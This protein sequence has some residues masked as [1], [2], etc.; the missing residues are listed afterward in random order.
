MR[1]SER[2][3]THTIG[4]I[5]L[6]GKHEE[7]AILHLAVVDDA[8]QLLAGLLDARAV[9]RVND[10][11]E[12]LGAAKVVPP[13]GANLVLASDVPHVEPH[14]L[15]RHRLDVEAHGGNRRHVLAQLELVQDRRL[16]G[17]VEAQHEEAHLLGSE[18]LAH[19]FGQR[20]TH[21]DGQHA[22]RRR[23]RWLGGRGGVVC[24][25]V[26]CAVIYLFAFSKGILLARRN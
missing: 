22:R 19:H 10:E 25:W 11:D 13:E 21:L 3:T 17:R 12:A 4:Q 6:V 14:V 15:V 23:G 16:A 18:D 20:A 26:V 5:L 24:R 2:G 9:R 7:Q 8:M 1:S